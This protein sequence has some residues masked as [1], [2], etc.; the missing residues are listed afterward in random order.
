MFGGLM[1][2]KNGKYIFL[3]IICAVVIAVGYTACKDIT[4]NQARIE[5]NVELKLSK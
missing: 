2:K 5:K 1:K 4:P 3:A